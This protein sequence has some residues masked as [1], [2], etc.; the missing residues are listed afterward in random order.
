MGHRRRV[1]AVG[2]QATLAGN[3]HLRRQRHQQVFGFRGERLVAQ[4]D[5]ATLEDRTLAE[6]SHAL[7]P[8]GAGG[9]LRLPGLHVCRAL[10]IVGVLLLERLGEPAPGRVLRGSRGARREVEVL[11]AAVR[12]DGP[13]RRQLLVVDAAVH[14]QLRTGVAADHLHLVLEVAS[15]PVDGVLHAA[16]PDDLEEH[17]VG[18]LAGHEAVALQRAEVAEAVLLRPATKTRALHHVAD[19]IVR[20]PVP[21]ALL[22]NAG[23]VAASHARHELGELLLQRRCS[24]VGANDIVR[25]DVGREDRSVLDLLEVRLREA[26]RLD[27]GD[28]RHVRGVVPA[29]LRDAVEVGLP[30][31]L[32]D[33][34]LEFLRRPQLEVEG[35]LSQPRTQFGVERNRGVVLQVLEDRGLGLEHVEVGAFAGVL[36]RAIAGLLEPRAEQGLA[37]RHLLPG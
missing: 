11:D 22:G 27:L 10:R 15:E 8:E 29:L 33:L 35:V 20:Q 23:H 37:A 12:V 3:N 21:A 13:H 26:A 5:G 7:E 4:V 25:R 2:R 18:V 16:L 6:R 24:S 34:S 19:L 32:A 17:P 36:V 9:G 30:H 1:F 31:L 28:Q 14:E